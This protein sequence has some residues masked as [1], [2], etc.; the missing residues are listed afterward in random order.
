MAGGGREL[1]ELV[2][3]ARCARLLPSRIPAQTADRVSTALMLHIQT[4]E[5]ENLSDGEGDDVGHNSGWGGQHRG[6]Q[7]P[8]Q[9]QL[10]QNA[11]ISI[12]HWEFRSPGSGSSS[13]LPAPAATARRGTKHTSYSD[14]NVLCDIFRRIFRILRTV[15]LLVFWWY[16]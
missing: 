11:L 7:Q 4:F 6:H 2:R 14:Q 9:Q 5:D 8:Q 12:S 1:R 13:P 10:H 16:N 3:P 15:F